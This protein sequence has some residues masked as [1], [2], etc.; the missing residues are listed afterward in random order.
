M[1]LLGKTDGASARD[2][3][4]Y[5]EIVSFI[6]ANG[7][8]PKKD[9]LELWKRIVFSMAIS[10]TDDHMRNHGFILGNN[11][12]ILSPMFDVNPDIYGNELSLNVNENESEINYELTIESACQYG[13]SK[14]EAIAEVERISDLVIDNW[15]K[16]AVKH[17]LSRGAIQRMKSAFNSNT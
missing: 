3:S 6:K 4:S 15:Q 13:L 14:D 17:G 2:G 16:I 9:L 12:W 1:T 11:G 10:N 7:A 8:Q 5:L